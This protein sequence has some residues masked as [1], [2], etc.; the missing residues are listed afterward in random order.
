MLN[1]KVWNVKS[2]Q[3]EHMEWVPLSDSSKPYAHMTCICIQTIEI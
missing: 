3:Q 2:I 1:N